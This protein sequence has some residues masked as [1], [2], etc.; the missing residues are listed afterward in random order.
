MIYFCTL[1]QS[2][3]AGGDKA[4]AVNDVTLSSTSLGRLEDGSTASTADIF[5]DNKLPGHAHGARSRDTNDQSFWSVN[6]QP[7]NHAQLGLTNDAGDQSVVYNWRDITAN[8][9]AD[10]SRV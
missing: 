4:A 8:H 6:V 10:S 7:P 5:S 1:L 9:A 2:A 3:K